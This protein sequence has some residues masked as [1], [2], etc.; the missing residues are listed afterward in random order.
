M[1]CKINRLD[2]C[3]LKDNS[4]K[5]PLLDFNDVDIS[6]DTFIY[7]YKNVNSFDFKE[8]D[9]ILID[10]NKIMLKEIDLNI[11]SYIHELIW[12]RNNKSIIIFQG[13]ITVQQTGCEQTQ[14]NCYI[15]PI[16]EC[17]LMVNILY[18]EEFFERGEQG[19]QGDQGEQGIQGEKGEQ[20]DQGEPGELGYVDFYIDEN[21]NLI[22]INESVADFYIENGFLKV[23]ITL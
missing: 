10:N 13:T 11:G 5:S 20:G 9:V 23:D 3:K 7:K 14:R 21:M 12:I 16:T 17:D 18:S 8:S 6:G 19:I 15:L 2:I 1:S 22:Y 4:F